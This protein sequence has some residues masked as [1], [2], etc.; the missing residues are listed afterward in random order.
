MG[1]ISTGAF[2]DTSTLIVPNDLFYMPLIQAFISEVANRMG[3]GRRDMAMM[4]VAVEE[5]VVNVV[6]HAFEPGEK[7][8]FQVVVAPGNTSLTVI[9][10]DK[11]M[12]YSPGVMSDYNPP[13]DIDDAARAGLGLYLIRKGVDEIFFYN[14]GREGKELHLV[15]HLPYRSVQ[16]INTAAELERFP[17][18]AATG[19]VEKKPFSIRLI[20]PSEVYDVSKLFYRAY[21]YT[22]NVDAIYYPEKLA[23]S[24]VDGTIISVVTVGEDDRVVGHAALVRDDRE[25]RTAELAMAVVEPSYRGHGCQNL[26][27]ARL[28]EEAK[29]EGLAGIYSKAVTNHMYAQKAGQKSG[30]K[31][32]A[33]IAGAIPKDRIYKGMDA[34]LSQRGS[35]AI[36]YRVVD[37]PGN[38]VVFVPARH[39]AIV[40]K[41][42]NELGIDRVFAQGPVRTQEILEGT[43]DVRVF[44]VPGFNRGVIEIKKF[45]NRVAEQ[46]RTILRTLCYQQVDQITLYSNLHDPALC[47]LIETFEEMGFFYAGILPFSHVGD[48]LLLQYLNNVPIDYSQVHV[49]CEMGREIL[50]Y[51][52][53]CDHNSR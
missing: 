1:N 27:T 34:A 45:G 51:V 17:E 47:G 35:V 13:S 46:V 33:V 28:V 24:H 26:M 7:A 21:G 44:V 43:G 40:Q 22:Y 20:K 49:A 19:P 23:Q 5:A 25:D 48:A 6:R 4:L 36:G 50:D 18:P 3:L 9:I 8:T 38:L 37:D 12:P 11:G 32:C 30:F 29:K 16:D 41:T 39:R 42:Y 52:R 53:S 2:T 15:K 31:R 14:L 10:K